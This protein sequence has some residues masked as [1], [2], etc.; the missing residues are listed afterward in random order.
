M[1][2]AVF[3]TDKPGLNEKRSELQGDFIAFLRE[4]RDH[5]DVV[6]HHSGPTL[7]EDGDTVVGMVNLIE[8]PSLASARAFVADSPYAKADIFDEIHVRQLDWRTGCPG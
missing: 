4:H 8:A 5:P 6:V 7:A 2:F 3:V 1:Y